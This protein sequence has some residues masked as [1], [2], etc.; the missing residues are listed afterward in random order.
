MVTTGGPGENL[1]TAAAERR[2]YDNEF[3]KTLTAEMKVIG[4]WQICLAK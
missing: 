4:I 1:T 2:P 3:G